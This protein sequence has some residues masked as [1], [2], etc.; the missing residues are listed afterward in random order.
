VGFPFYIKVCSAMEPQAGVI[1]VKKVHL[2]LC[3]RQKACSL[4]YEDGN[5]S[6]RATGSMAYE[7]IMFPQACM[8]IITSE[9]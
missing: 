4:R 3:Y 1:L 8:L 7:D 5:E 6:E 9:P 2:G